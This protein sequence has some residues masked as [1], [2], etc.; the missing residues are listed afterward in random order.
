MADREVSCA[1]GSKQKISFRKF[2]I[3]F[4]IFNILIHGLDT[5]DSYRDYQTD[6]AP[7]FTS[8]YIDDVPTVSKNVKTP[9]SEIIQTPFLSK[10]TTTPTTTEITSSSSENFKSIDSISKIPSISTSVDVSSSTTL[11]T[12][13]SFSS[14][15]TTL[16]EIIKT[17]AYSS[18]VVVP[19][20]SVKN[21][22]SYQSVNISSTSI[23]SRNISPTI[24]S[25]M[26]L[27]SIHGTNISSVSVIANVSS[28]DFASLI[29]PSCYII[30]T[31]EV[32][33]PTASSVI[34]SSSLLPNMSSEIVLSTNSIQNS[35]EIGPTTIVSTHILSSSLN[36]SSSIVSMTTMLPSSSDII[37]ASSSFPVIVSTSIV[38]ASILVPSV[39][40][41]D[42]VASNF[43][44]ALNNYTT[45]MLLN[46]KPME[47]C[48][49]CS[50]QYQ[51]VKLFHRKIYHDCGKHLI[52]R[53][54]SQYQVIAGLFQIQK[55]S[56]DSL[57]CN[58]E[59]LI[60]IFVN[61]HKTYSVKVKIRLKKVSYDYV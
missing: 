17:T 58:S 50:Q 24:S 18:V 5:Q 19:T 45:C 6:I 30:T 12:E 7:I 56:W 51:T 41:C 9:A 49:K 13:I 3:Y 15:K 40:V 42:I 2:I 59:F 54:N 37:N 44:I 4:S 1:C 53:Y 46:L 29:Q 61:K 11:T 43:T 20:S 28:T 10:T 31:T 52:G 14:L 57:E 23:S 27:T 16:T 22:S 32:I 36:L 60:L 34:Q 33:C 26:I 39:H 25:Q 38:N 48:F 47:V 21:E 35:T 8:N 55:Q